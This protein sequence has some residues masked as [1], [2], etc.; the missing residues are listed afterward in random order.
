MPSIIFRSIT[1]FSIHVTYINSF[2]MFAVPIVSAA[3]RQPA[4]SR[5]VRF[6]ARDARR[7]ET[8]GAA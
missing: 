6:E 8:L 4:T 5:Q 7:S 3:A 2:A 1:T